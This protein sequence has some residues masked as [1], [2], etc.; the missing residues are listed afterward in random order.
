[1]SIPKIE[2]NIGQALKLLNPFAKKKKLKQEKIKK[3]G[4]L[5]LGIIFKSWENCET[6]VENVLCPE[7][8]PLTVY[9]NEKSQYSCDGCKKNY[10]LGGVLRRCSIC[11]W[12]CCENCFTKL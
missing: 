9:N 1:M 12:D 5:E 3:I 11:D 8:H 6:Y 2:K 4:T 7:G 10:S